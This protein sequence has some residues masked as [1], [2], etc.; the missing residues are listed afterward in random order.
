MK[1][2]LDHNINPPNTA[3]HNRSERIHCAT[4]LGGAAMRCSH[5]MRTCVCEAVAVLHLQASEGR[6][7]AC[8]VQSH[9]REARAS[10]EQQR[11]Q[12]WQARYGTL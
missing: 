2:K 6:G 8:A 9:A 1:S 5:E 3:K 12:L 7:S 11:R 10:V 4:R